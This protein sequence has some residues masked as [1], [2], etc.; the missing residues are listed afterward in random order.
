MKRALIAI[1]VGLVMSIGVVPAAA[2]DNQT[3]STG[4]IK[5]SGSETKQAGKSLGKNMKQGR[6]VRGSK[7]FGKHMGRAGKHFGRSTKKVFKKI[8]S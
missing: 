7:S 4:E 6:V 8:I 1:S 3:T 2:Q 5:K